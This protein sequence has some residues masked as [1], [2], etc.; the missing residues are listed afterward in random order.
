MKKCNRAF[1]RL[2]DPAAVKN[3][4]KQAEWAF[5]VYYTFTFSGW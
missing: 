4:M 3:N 2:V 5:A 1:M